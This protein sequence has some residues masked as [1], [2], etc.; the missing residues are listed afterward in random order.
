MPKRKQLVEI[1]GKT[2]DGKIV[3][4]GLIRFK[5]THGVPLENILDYLGE[6]F[7]PSWRHLLNEAIGTSV[8]REQF[9]KELKSAIIY[10]YGKDF[11]ERIWWYIESYSWEK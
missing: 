3:V 10:A 4:G 5:E 8:K 9:L 7:V 6:N 2:V 11:L 1:V